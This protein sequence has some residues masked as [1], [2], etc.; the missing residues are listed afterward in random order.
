MSV[1]QVIAFFQAIKILKARGKEVV[2]AVSGKQV[3]PRDPEHFPR[4]QRLINSGG[5]ARNFRLLGLIPHAHIPALMRSC[6]GLINPSKFE[7]WSTTVEEAKAMG[8]PMI[9][10][11]LRVHREQSAEALFFNADIPEELAEILAD[12]KVAEHEVRLQMSIAGAHRACLAMKIFSDRFVDLM[13]LSAN[14]K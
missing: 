6:S 2:I 7:G 4:L 3:D 10:S 9:L 11:S 1:N 13:E 14:Q 8:T 5:L 12:F